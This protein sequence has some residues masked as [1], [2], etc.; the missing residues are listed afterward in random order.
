M[1]V[2]IR[3][4]IIQERKNFP[5]KKKHLKSLKEDFGATV[6]ATAIGYSIGKLLFG[7]LSK[8]FP[9]LKEWLGSTT[10][11]LDAADEEIMGLIRAREETPRSRAEEPKPPSTGEVPPPPSTGVEPGPGVLPDLDDSEP[12]VVLD[13]VPAINI[14]RDEYL[15]YLRKVGEARK[16]FKNT[17]NQLM[18]VVKDPKKASEMDQKPSELVADKLQALIDAYES[19][20]QQHPEEYNENGKFVE[21]ME[22]AFEKIRSVAIGIRNID[23]MSVLASK[24]PDSLYS[25][26]EPDL[27]KIFD[28]DPSNWYNF[29]N[30]ISAAT[31]DANTDV[32]SDKLKSTAGLTESKKSGKRRNVK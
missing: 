31:V 23:M 20:K 14:D 15:Q 25:K 2:I 6:A 24:G 9:K 8:L 29:V 27:K 28:R 4:K 10:K 7:L 22:K 32:A 18:E 26:V 19:V 3:R 30:L 13:G 17:V 5:I 21:A 16:D 1:R 12:E 11:T